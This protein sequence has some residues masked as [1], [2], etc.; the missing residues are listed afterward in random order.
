M[1]DFDISNKEHLLPLIM[2]YLVNN[3]FYKTAK[4][5]KIESKIDLE[6]DTFPIHEKKLENIIDFYCKYWNALGE[7]GK[8]KGSFRKASV[9]INNLTDMST[10]VAPM[11]KKVGKKNGVS[12][13]VK[14]KVKAVPKKTKVKKVIKKKKVIVK[15]KAKT[16]NEENKQEQ[17]KNEVVKKKK[18]ITKKLKLEKLENRRVKKQ[19]NYQKFKEKSEA[20]TLVDKKLEVKVNRPN[21]FSR[22]ANVKK[23]KMDLFDSKWSNK[24]MK[25]GE[26]GFG[27]L[28][29][30]RLAH[31]RG[32]NFKKEKHKLKNREFQ[33]SKITFRNN[34]IDLD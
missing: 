26:D 20:D 3:E 22:C 19:E 9:E 12:K 25:G 27:A 33:G 31:T 13:V 1:E 29:F 34:L 5:L 10:P 8:R 2:K 28:G 30:Q 4:K 11:K 24:V 14:T 15:K 16:G 6:S 17:A 23:V 32:K 21:T 18:K 7:P